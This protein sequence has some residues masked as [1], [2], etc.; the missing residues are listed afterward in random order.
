M[1][2]FRLFSSRRRL[3]F[4]ARSVEQHSNEVRD[5]NRSMGQSGLRQ[6]RRAGDFGGDYDRHRLTGEHEMSDMFHM[7]GRGDNSGDN[8]GA[9]DAG[10]GDNIIRARFGVSDAG[11]GRGFYRVSRLLAR[12]WAMLRAWH[13]RRIAVRE[14]S[15]MPD[16]LLRDIGIER[17]QI[18]AAVNGAYPA[19]IR[20]PSGRAGAD[21][22]G[23]A[24][25]AAAPLAEVKQ[26]A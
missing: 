17:Y 23:G 16:A 19:I 4:P 25:L 8:S 13:N 7:H 22:N 5:G 21:I 11:R 9:H 24:G 1:K 3:T 18:R 2:I 20:L 15:A 6:Y 14:L 10:R 12:A 26:A